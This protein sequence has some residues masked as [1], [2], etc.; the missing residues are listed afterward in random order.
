MKSVKREIEDLLLCTVISCFISDMGLLL[1]GRTRRQLMRCL[2][3]LVC[4]LQIVP[5]ECVM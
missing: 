4:I 1:S 2:I 5:A 3:P